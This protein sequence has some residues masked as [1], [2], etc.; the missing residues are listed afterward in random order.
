MISRTKILKEDKKM[1]L[2]IALF[3]VMVIWIDFLG[4]DISRDLTWRQNVN[5]LICS[6]FIWPF[7]LFLLVFLCF[8]R[9]QG[10]M[11]L[12]SWLALIFY[13]QLIYGIAIYWLILFT[14]I[15]LLVFFGFVCLVYGRQKDERFFPIDGIE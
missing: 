6:V 14:M 8:N 3:L 5:N 13:Y 12:V 2:S 1:A 4:E 7:Q 15:W 11:A 9:W 10:K